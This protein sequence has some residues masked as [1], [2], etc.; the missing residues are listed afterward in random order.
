MN[1]FFEMS[2][3]P[4]CFVKEREAHRVVGVGNRESQRMMEQPSRRRQEC[5]KENHG[6]DGGNS[7]DR[8]PEV[9]RF[10]PP[11][12]RPREEALVI[13]GGFTVGIQPLG[14]ASQDFGYSVHKLVGCLSDLHLNPRFI[15]CW[16]FD[17][18]AWKAMF[19]AFHLKIE[20]WTFLLRLATARQV[21][22]LLAKAF[23]VGGFLPLYRFNG[24][25]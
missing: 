2:G 13:P 6:S 16:M 15:E 8:V 5:L 10:G 22:A 7:K 12:Q 3:I 25:A 1:R 24:L 19:R 17:V 18:L 14:E 20:C 21:R 4:T 23:G 11:T 9:K